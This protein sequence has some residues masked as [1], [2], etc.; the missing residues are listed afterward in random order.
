M[1]A[2]EG[3]I[4]GGY[5]GLTPEQ[6]V[7]TLLGHAEECRFSKPFF[8]HADHITIKDSSTDELTRAET[9]LTAQLQAGFTSFALDASF[10]PLAENIRIISQLARPVI[11]AG[12]GLEV[13]LGEVKH[14]GAESDL[15]TVA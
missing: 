11:T 3:G 14:V 12:F 7:D 2:T 6:F 13:E 10:N 9:L 1:T 8:I 15:T 5:T 4:D